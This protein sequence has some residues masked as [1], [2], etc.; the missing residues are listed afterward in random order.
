MSKINN[1]NNTNNISKTKSN[2]KKANSLLPKELV[3]EIQKYAQGQLIYIPKD[4]NER[5][6][7]G[8]NSGGR[9]RI[10]ERN[11]EINKSFRDGMAIDALAE[12]YCLS[13]ESIKKIVYKCI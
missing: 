3:K 8:E 10:N 11:N 9:K 5:Q 1:T 2:Y 12:K 7:W 13:V 4:K 6:K